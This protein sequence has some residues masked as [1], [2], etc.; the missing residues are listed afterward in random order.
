MVANIRS[1]IPEPNFDPANV[2]FSFEMKEESNFIITLKKHQADEPLEDFKLELK[3]LGQATKEGYWPRQ[4]ITEVP[5][6]QHNTEEERDSSDNE[7]ETN[8]NVWTIWSHII[9]FAYDLI[10][11]LLSKITHNSWEIII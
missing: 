9:R 11:R 4:L 10:G 8:V 3:M 2:E 7:Q 5:Q 6:P 1:T